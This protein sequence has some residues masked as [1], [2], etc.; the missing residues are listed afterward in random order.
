MPI[1]LKTIS[2]VG[3]WFFTICPCD[4]N[5]LGLVTQFFLKRWFLEPFSHKSPIVNNQISTSTMTNLFVIFLVSIQTPND[6]QF[7]IKL[8]TILYRY[9]ALIGPFH[10]GPMITQF[11][12]NISPMTKSIN[13]DIQN[14]SQSFVKLQKNKYFYLVG[15]YI[16]FPIYESQCDL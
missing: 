13:F 1:F 16:D 12:F 5:G 8:T 11:H 7:I 3:L 9:K 2:L 15:N 10:H 14:L 4:Y 6:C